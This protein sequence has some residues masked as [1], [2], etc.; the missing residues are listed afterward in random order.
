MSDRSYDEIQEIKA[1]YPDWRSAVMPALRLAQ[2][3][4]TAGCRRTRCA[5]S[6]TRST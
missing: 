6:P 2:E 5:R 4:A 1:Q 3:R